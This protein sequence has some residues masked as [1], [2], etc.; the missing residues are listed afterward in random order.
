[1]LSAPSVGGTI[2]IITKSLDAKKGG[3][4]WAGMGNDGMYQTGVSLST[5]LMNNGW[6]VTLLGSYKEGDGYIQGTF[7]KAYNYFVNVSKRIND[8][9]QLSLTAFGSPQ[10]H[11]KRGSADGL[12]IEGWQNVRN[13]MGETNRYKYNPTYGFDQ[14]GQMRSSNMNTYHKPQISLAH[15]WQIDYKSSLSTSIYASFATGGGY[16]GQGRG[17]Y[18][19]NTISY[20][21]WYGASDGIVNTLFR[22]ADGTFAYDEIQ[23]MNEKSTTGSNMVMSQSNNSHNWYGLVSTYK[24]EFMPKKL[25]LTAGID[26]RYYV[27]KH[28]NKIIDLYNGAYYID[29]SSRKSVK[30]ENNAAAADPNWMYEKLSV[31]DIVYRNYDGHT[32]QEGA[33]A[34]LEYTALD[35]KLNAVVSGSLSNTGYWRVDHFYYDKAHATSAKL[36]FLGGTA[37]GGVNYNIDRHN[38]VFVNAGYISRAPFFSGG[39]FLTSTVSNATNPNAINEKIASVEGGYGYHSPF[40]SA[41]V[42]AYYTLWMD[43]TSTRSGDITSGEHAGDR[44]YFNMDGVDA[45]HMGVELN[46]IYKPTKWLELNG[47]LSWGDYVWNSNATGY[48]YNQN[49]EPL[50]DL[51]GNIASGIQAE[52]HARATLNQ[53]GVKVGGSAQTT[54]ALGFSLRPFKGMRLGADWV[55]NARNYSDYTISSSSYQAGANINVAEP[56]RIPWGNQLDLSASYSFQMGGT[57]ATLSGN[58]NNLFDHYYVMDAYTKTDTTGAWDNAYRVFYSFGRTFSLRLKVRF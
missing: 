54:G 50:S 27:G 47:M 30:A 49:G 39:A 40:F 16:S 58:V 37:K 11:N 53:K 48:F 15:I 17:T 2:N 32:H 34:Q 1:M 4:V 29:D 45:R 25:T 20:S 41:D 21:S 10:R 26:M 13:Y 51:R 5:G 55:F 57:N 6:A 44:Y 33:Y 23:T 18:N 31:G 19:G 42:N 7:F 36:N 14:N 35:G 43:K 28:N 46:F 52:D 9:H 38:N 8:S 12:T 22:K 3:N 24:N 56:W